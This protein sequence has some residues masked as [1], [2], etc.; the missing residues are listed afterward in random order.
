[1]LDSDTKGIMDKYCLILER[2]L[3]LEGLSFLD[4][5]Y[6]FDASLHR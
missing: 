5:L 1:M 3:L 4:Y 2:I 6:S